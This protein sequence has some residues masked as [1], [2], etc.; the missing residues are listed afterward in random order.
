MAVNSNCAELIEKGKK[1]TRILDAC[2]NNDILA[3]TPE[4]SNSMILTCH[5]VIIINE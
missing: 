2:W 1:L 4:G 5:I 3:L